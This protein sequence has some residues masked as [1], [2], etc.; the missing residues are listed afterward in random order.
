[1]SGRVL[2][3]DDSLTV[4]MDLLEQLVAAGLPAMACGT[5]AEARQALA[6]NRFLLVILDVLLPDGDGV[7]LLEEIRAGPS[8][9]STA[10]MLLSTESEI[11]D[12]IRGLARGADE[13]VGKPYEPG[14]VIARARE[15]VRRGGITTPAAQETVLL[16]DDSVTF[17]EELKAVLENASYRVVVAESGEEGL[18]LAVDLRPAAIIVDGVLPGIDGAAVIRRIRFDSALRRVPCLLLTASR[19]RW[20]CSQFSRSTV[21]CSISSCR[22]SA[23]G[24]PADA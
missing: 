18:R 19:K 6:E 20:I 24:K 7:Q 14:Y 13:Y 10:V 2:I 15:L 12:R 8:A 3:V 21:S 1:M 5:A 23:V 11:R 16:I 4:R 9:T 17:R 22:A